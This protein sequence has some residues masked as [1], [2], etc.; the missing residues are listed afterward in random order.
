VY[1]GD[2]CEEV[3]YG[4]TDGQMGLVQLS[5]SSCVVMSAMNMFI[6]PSP[7]HSVGKA[8]CFWAVGLSIHSFVRLSGQ[9]LLPGHFVKGLSSLN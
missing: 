5:R 1:I 4:T 9:I 8:L 3:L 6:M 2:S 7:P